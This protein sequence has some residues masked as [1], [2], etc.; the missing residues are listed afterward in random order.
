M[1][2]SYNLPLIEE[3]EKSS[4]L[5]KLTSNAP[6]ALDMKEGEEESIEGLRKLAAKEKNPA[7]KREIIKKINKLK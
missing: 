2:K 7:A 6:K 3:V 4:L 5:N 1:R